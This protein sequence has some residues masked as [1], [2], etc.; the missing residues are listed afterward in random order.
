MK[1][2]GHW[3]LILAILLMGSIGLSRPA[4]A[5][6]DDSLARVKAKGTLVMGTSPNYPPYEFQINENGKSKIVGMDVEIGKQIAKDLGVKLVIKKLSFDSLLPALTTG[7]VDM[8][9]SG[10]SPTSARRKSVDF[11][12]I[13]YTEGE[14]ILLNKAD[15]AKY[16]NKTALNGQKVAAETG[17]MQYD[18]IKQQMPN[19]NLVGMSSAANLI[20]A[21]KTHKVAAV[22]K[23]TASATA[24]A[25]NDPSLVAVNGNFKT[26]SAQAGNAIALRKGSSSLTTAINQSLAKIKSQHLIQRQYLKTAGKHLKVNTADTSMW[27][28]RNY[29]LR[30]L[31]Y[32]LIIA[33]I[34]IIGGSILGL[35]LTLLRIS[36][37]TPLRWLATAYVEFV[38]GTPLMVQIMFVYFGIGMIVDVSALNAGIIA[39]I[40]NSGAYLSEIIRGGIQAVDAGQTEAAASLGLSRTATL[41]YVVLPQTLKII[42]PALGNQFINLIK[43]TSM[44][45]IIGV[46]ELIYQLGIVQADTYRGVAP[47]G[48]AMVLYFIICWLLTR[49]LHYYEKRLNKGQLAY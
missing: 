46:T 14:S 37:I 1:H 35:L 8:I 33:V 32:T 49:L 47:I 29:F 25:K 23:G 10:M 20:L 34:G 26:S 18:L 40:L 9:L 22:V 38:R 27:H 6:T 30:G 36:L 28:Y 11:T 31:K 2:L 12:N 19:T 15:L 17:T 39:I 41:R 13:Y 16:K 43:D 7:K 48:I 3:L 24:Y 42:W 45:S 5:A 44:V 21:L 4:H